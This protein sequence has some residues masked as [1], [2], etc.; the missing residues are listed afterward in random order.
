MRGVS[1]V[2]YDPHTTLWSYYMLVLLNLFLYVFPLTR[3]ISLLFLR[4]FPREGRA[5]LQITPQTNLLIYHTSLQD[6]SGV[7]FWFRRQFGPVLGQI[8]WGK[9]PMVKELKWTTTGLHHV[10]VYALLKFGFRWEDFI[11]LIW[12][13][14]GTCLVYYWKMRMSPYSRNS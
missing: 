3:F 4:I 1:I 8:R 6:K 11:H 2:P 10:Y 9:H 14:M 5:N 13:S 7:C 12:L